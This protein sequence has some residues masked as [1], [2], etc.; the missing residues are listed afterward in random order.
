MSR[1]EF[2][3]LAG[4]AALAFPFASPAQ[5][6]GRVYRIAWVHPTNSIADMSQN[7][8]IRGYRAFVDE[9]RRLGYVEGQNLILERFSAEGRQERYAELA[10]DV[11]RLKPDL[12]F[13]ISVP[14][15]LQFKSATTTIA[16]VTLTGDPVVYGLATSVAHP[17]G[18]LTGV[19]IDAGLEIWG[20]RLALLQE[21]LPRLSKVGFLVT[22]RHWDYIQGH[23]D[24]VR[25]AAQRLGIVLSGLLLDESGKGADYQRVLAALSHDRVDALVV[26]D[27]PE[28][29][30]NR[31]ILVELAETAGVPAIYPWREHCELGG[32]MAYAFED[33]AEG[34][35][36]PCEACG[37]TKLAFPHRL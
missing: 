33:E 27:D 30:T 26:S 19:V 37:A 15:A 12:I 10:H 3:A 34:K 31:S 13:A 21:I 32:L 17:G 2:I 8:P 36:L 20:K 18:N 4:G 9:L 14:M 6:V 11:V 23:G 35:V 1:R 16:T 28:N 5:Q 25:Q 24:F 29:F 22:R 7:S